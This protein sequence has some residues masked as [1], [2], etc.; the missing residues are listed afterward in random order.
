MIANVRTEN[1]EEFTLTLDDNSYAAGKFLSQIK[2]KM[3]DDNYKIEIVVDDDD[4][5]EL[6]DSTSY[7]GI[8]YSQLQSW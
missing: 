7:D 1:G 4:K 3:K 6:D 2:K 5:W 8:S